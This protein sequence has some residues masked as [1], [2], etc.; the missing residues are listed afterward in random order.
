MH[1]IKYDYLYASFLHVHRYFDNRDVRK[2]AQTRRVNIPP[3]AY[4]GDGQNPLIRSAVC[5]DQPTLAAL[6]KP[7]PSPRSPV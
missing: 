3:V 1:S 7:E 2:K 6:R 4:P 5:A